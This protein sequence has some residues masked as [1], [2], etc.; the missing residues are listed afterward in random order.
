MEGVNMAS[1]L[2]DTIVS[3]QIQAA[4]EYTEMLGTVLTQSVEKFGGNDNVPPEQVIQ[5]GIAT[6]N[7]III[8]LLSSI[9]VELHHANRPD[10]D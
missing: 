4:E 7:I 1:S 3:Q 6:S 2:A 9:L 10:S 5:V 8:G